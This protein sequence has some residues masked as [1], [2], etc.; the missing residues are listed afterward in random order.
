MATLNINTTALAT[1]NRTRINLYKESD[2]TAIVDTITHDAPHDEE[3]WSFFDL[4]PSTN[5]RYR[6]I[7]IDGSGTTL[8]QYASQTFTTPAAGSVVIKPTAYLYVDATPG[9]TSGTT[10]ATFD[11]TNGTEDYRGWDITVDMP[12]FGDQFPDENYT[13]DKATGEFTLLGG[14]E[15]EPGVKYTF[16]FDPKVIAT[17]GPV[18]KDSFTGIKYVT[19]DETLLAADFGANLIQVDGAGATVE[20]TLPDIA[21]VAPL[22]LLHIKTGKGNHKSVTITSTNA[23]AFDFMEG[24]RT[25]IYLG[26]REKVSIYK[27]LKSGVS[28]WQVIDENGNFYSVGQLVGEFMPVANVFNKIEANDSAYSSLEY[29]RLY[30]DYVLKLSSDEVVAFADWTANSRKFS[31]ANGSNQFHVPDL[32]NLYPRAVTTGKN[33]GDYLDESVKGHSHVFPGDDSMIGWTHDPSIW[34]MRKVPGSPT[35]PGDLSSSSGSGHNYYLTSDYGGDE[36]RPKTFY[37]R[38]YIL[39]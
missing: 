3:V 21:T 34:T 15:F 28:T 2:P 24:N 39:T 8:Q 10:S 23:N 5:Y 32:R 27:Q 7:E 25:K 37:T 13:W 11:G 20:L 18:T 1:S 29:A 12:G 17:T 14:A 33:P 31:Y 19:A 4:E 26:V 16:Q 36:T 9:L 30:N 35:R 6:W 22:K 38:I